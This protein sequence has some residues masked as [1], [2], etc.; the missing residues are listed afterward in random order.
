MLN[1][2]L[3]ELLKTIT[4]CKKT[5]NIARFMENSFT[6][7]REMSFPDALAFMLDMR[8]TTLQT[9]LNLYFEHGKGCQ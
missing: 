3:L 4:Y 1:L 2:D 7:S 6:R 8:K 5:L 9:R